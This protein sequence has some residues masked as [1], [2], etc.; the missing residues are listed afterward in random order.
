MVTDSFHAGPTTVENVNGFVRLFSSA[1]LALVRSLLS[2]LLL[3]SLAASF[4]SSDFAY[5]V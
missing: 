5:L 1:I 4:L 3:S 2:S